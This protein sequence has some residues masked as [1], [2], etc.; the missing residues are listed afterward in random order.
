MILTCP[1]CDTRFDVPPA[2]FASGGRKVKC[3]TCKHVWFQDE[4]L[5]ALVE[6]I[7]DRVEGDDNFA[8]TLSQSNGV[9]V[10]EAATTTKATNKSSALKVAGAS[11][12]TVLF[13]FFIYQILQPSLVMGEGLAFN[14][15][16]IEQTQEGLILT[17]EI[18]NT[19]RDE[20]GVP[21]L[22]ITS[23]LGEDMK[24]DVRLVALD[25]DVLE[26][27][28]VLPVMIILDDVKDETQKLDVT[29]EKPND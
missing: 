9:G 27:G 29:F 2:I 7:A 28:E 24:G 18:V 20:R 5:E 26:G 23:I 15:M 6:T 12:I 22:Q 13:L 19:V 14:D 10:T 3:A 4:P 25:K 16:M 8:D 21:S 1:Q 11:C 17:G